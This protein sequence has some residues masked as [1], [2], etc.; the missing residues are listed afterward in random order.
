MV[1]EREYTWKIWDFE[2][3]HWS[4]LRWTNAGL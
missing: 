1:R 4:I 2:H 3:A